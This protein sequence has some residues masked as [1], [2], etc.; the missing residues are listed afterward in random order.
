MGCLQV[1]NTRKGRC[2]SFRIERESLDLEGVKLFDKKEETIPSPPSTIHRETIIDLVDP[3][4]PVNHVAPTDD[5]HRHG[6][7]PGDAYMG[8]RYSTKGRGTCN[9]LV[10]LYV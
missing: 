1:S 8:W 4:D 6:G 9:L 10:Q 5:S 3:V 7:R 2:L